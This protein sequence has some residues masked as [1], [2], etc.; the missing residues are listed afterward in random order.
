[1]H[2]GG[3]NATE[4]S[5]DR[6]QALVL[7]DMH[8]EDDNIRSAIAIVAHGLGAYLDDTRLKTLFG[9]VV[10]NAAHTNTV[11]TISGRILVAANVLHTA[12]RRASA[13]RS[14]VLD[15]IRSG[16]LDDRNAIRLTSVKYSYFIFKKYNLF[17]S[18]YNILCYG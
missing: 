16:M 7:G 12:G 13:Y 1:L 8:D 11:A 15:M 3:A 18:L 9:T 10:R 5:L 2:S 17:P 14:E 4:I 6:L